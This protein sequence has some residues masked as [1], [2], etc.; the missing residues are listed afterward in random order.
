MSISLICSNSVLL[1]CKRFN[2]NRLHPLQTF[3]IV[4]HVKGEVIWFT[5]K[6][7]IL[8]SLKI[9]SIIINQSKHIVLKFLP[10]LIEETL[11]LI[12]D[13]LKFISNA[14]LNE[15]KLL[16]RGTFMY[17][18]K[19]ICKSSKLLAFYNTFNHVC[20]IREIFNKI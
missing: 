10:Y 16:N 12:P 19:K 13:V 7:N 9:L 8:I 14:F 6:D 1:R 17:T 18:N 11:E 2:H 3:L 20:A 4:R 5:I 15:L